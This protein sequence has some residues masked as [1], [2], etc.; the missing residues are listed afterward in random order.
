[1]TTLPR[2]RRF[3][4]VLQV[5][6]LLLGPTLVIAETFHNPT[7]DTLQL[8]ASGPTL[9]YVVLVIALRRVKAPPM[10]MAEPFGPLASGL[11]RESLCCQP[12]PYLVQRLEMSWPCNCQPPNAPDPMLS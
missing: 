8:G 1:M 10:T 11:K 4:I 7:R 12:S 3:A 2:C 9:A 6:G 5:W